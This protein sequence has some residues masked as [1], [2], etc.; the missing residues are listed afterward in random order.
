MTTNG[1]EIG[2]LHPEHCA[3]CAYYKPEEQPLRTDG[4][5][6]PALAG[7]EEVVR[8]LNAY[9]GRSDDGFAPLQRCTAFVDNMS[10]TASAET[11][12]RCEL[13]MY[14]HRLSSAYYRPNPTDDPVEGSVG[15]CRIRSTPEHVERYDRDWCGEFKRG[16][17]G[18]PE[19]N[20]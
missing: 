10:D 18:R 13:C 16:H 1:I 8:Q 9:Y 17:K 19:E 20:R 3:G 12:E 7:D 14:Y 6:H 5:C 4:C 15:R 11:V 2:P